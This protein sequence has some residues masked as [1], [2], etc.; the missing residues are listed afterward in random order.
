MNNPGLAKTFHAAGAIAARRIVKFGATAGTIVQAVADADAL[1]GVC[2]Q[3]GGAASGARVDAYLTGIVEVDYGAT[4]AA[5][6]ML[7]ADADGKAVPVVRHTHDASNPATVKRVIGMAM[8]SGSAGDIGSV[9]L[10]PSL[11]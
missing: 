10:R 1:I 6:D 9:L 11:A 7:T 3:P 8:V 4:V 2:A 5:G